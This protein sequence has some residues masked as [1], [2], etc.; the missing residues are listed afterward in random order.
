[1]ISFGRKHCK[2][3]MHKYSHVSFEGI[4][5]RYFNDDKDDTAQIVCKN[6]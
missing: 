3:D 2:Y 4:A 1:M 5:F 6:N